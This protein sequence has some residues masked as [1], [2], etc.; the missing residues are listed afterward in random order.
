M[1]ERQAG[2]Q[3]PRRVTR[4]TAATTVAAGAPHAATATGAESSRTT[5][6]VP[7]TTHAAP[8]AGAGS[9]QT[10]ATAPAKRP[11]EASPPPPRAG[12]APDFDF[13]AFSSDEEEEEE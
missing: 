7:A 10:A 11:R 13:S 1:A 9:S 4:S 8:V 2:Q 3:S 6:S 5:A 12:R